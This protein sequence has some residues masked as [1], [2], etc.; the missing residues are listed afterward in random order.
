M[1]GWNRGVIRDRKLF[2]K[3]IRHNYVTPTQFY[4]VFE[5]ITDGNIRVPDTIPDGPILYRFYTNKDNK[6]VDLSLV[7]WG[8][9]EC[10]VVFLPSFERIR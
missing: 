7:L 4:Y 2:Y 8:G 5:E 9:T 3:T 6:T 1:K 10:R